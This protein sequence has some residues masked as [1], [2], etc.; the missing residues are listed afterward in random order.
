M[1]PDSVLPCTPAFK[2]SGHGRSRNFLPEPM[3]MLVNISVAFKRRR[4]RDIPASPIKDTMHH[5]TQTIEQLINGGRKIV[6]Q[7]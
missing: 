2:G 7:R 6:I 3:I 5:C 1:P 4:T